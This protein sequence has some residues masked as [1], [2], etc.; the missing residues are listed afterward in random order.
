MG[1]AS[2]LRTVV[3][4]TA[5]EKLRSGVAASEDDTSDDVIRTR[6]LMS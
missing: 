4:G 5:K 1:L 3:R 2:L 6:R